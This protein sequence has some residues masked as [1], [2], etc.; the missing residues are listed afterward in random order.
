MKNKLLL[1][2][3]F[4]VPLLASTALARIGETHQEFQ[5]RCG[6]YLDPPRE[7]FDDQGRAQWFFV[8]KAGLAVAVVFGSG[9]HSVS[10][11][12]FHL[13]RSPLTRR[14]INEILDRQI[15]SFTTW[16]SSGTGRWTSVDAFQ[17]EMRAA[18]SGGKLRVWVKEDE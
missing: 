13:N 15:S 10:E 16:K 5:T 9:A 6:W 2:S 1:V 7:R 4:L 8:E 11:T 12:F 17:R 3:L 14:E 18:Y